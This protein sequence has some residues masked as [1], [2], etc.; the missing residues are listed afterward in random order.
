M[1]RAGRFQKPMFRTVVRYLD[2]LQL[3]AYLLESVKKGTYLREFALGRP[4]LGSL[5]NLGGTVVVLTE[6]RFKLSHKEVQ[7]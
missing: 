4:Y 2:F 3:S 6:H 5:Y 1:S 7:P